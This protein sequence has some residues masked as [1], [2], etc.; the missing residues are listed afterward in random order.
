MSYTRPGSNALSGRTWPAPYIASASV[1]SS[2]MFP[3]VLSIWV[4]VVIM[5]DLMAAGLQYG[6]ATFNKAAN[7]F[8]MWTWHRGTRDDIKCHF[9]GVNFQ[10]CWACSAPSCQYVHSRASDVRLQNFGCQRIGSSWGEAN[11]CRCRFHIQLRPKKLKL[12]N[13]VEGAIH[14]SYENGSSFGTHMV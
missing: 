2:I 10:P 6:W 12:S 4:A 3:P 11:Y 13:W 7:P 9:L 8:D 14:V 5:A 1:A